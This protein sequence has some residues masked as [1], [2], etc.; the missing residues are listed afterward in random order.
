[1]P[2]GA[3]KYFPKTL[4]GLQSVTNKSAFINGY[5]EELDIDLKERY[6]TKVRTPATSGNVYHYLNWSKEVTGV[7]DAR[8]IP[9]ANGNGTVKVVII[10]SNKTGADAT[11]INSVKAHIED[12][13]PIGATV[14]VISDSEVP[15]NISVSLVTDDL[16]ATKDQIKLNIESEIKSYLKAIAFNDTYISYAKIGAILLGTTGVKDY[17]NLKI[18]NS[19]TNVNIADTEVATF[20][21]VTIV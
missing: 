9:L 4:Q 19:T 17:S 14:T 2:I 18:N 16:I 3:I 5:D 13:R 1:M 10:N 8:V 6:Y 11:L 15:I 20:G 21:G 12:E 7:G